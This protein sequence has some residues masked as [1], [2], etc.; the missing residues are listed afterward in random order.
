MRNEYQVVIIGGGVVGTFIAR[1]LSRYRLRVLLL[2]AENDLAMGATK[3]NSGII[4]G[5]FAESPESLRGKL[6]Y[7]GRCAFPRLEEELHFGYRQTGSLVL[8]TDPLE[9]PG[10]EALLERGR[11]N[12]LTDLSI[13]S[14]DE[15]LAMEPRV[16]PSVLGALF[17]RGAGVASPYEL[18]IALGENAVSNGVEIRLSSPVEQ[19]EARDEG[20]ILTLSRG[21][22]APEGGAS[23]DGWTGSLKAAGGDRGSSVTADFVINA[24]GVY[25]DRVA[26]MIGDNE[27]SIHPSKGEY[28]LFARG[29]GSIVRNVL[30]QMPTRKGKGVLVTST[31]HGNLMIGPDAQDGT[32]PADTGTDLESIRTILA[33]A[34]LT[35]KD[36]D[37]KQF[38][39]TFSGVRAISSTGDFIIGPSGINSRFIHVAGIQSPG[40]TASPAIARMVM[41]ILE[42]R[43]LPVG[44][45]AKPESLNPEFNPYRQAIIRPKTMTMKEAVKRTELPFGNLDRI[46]CRCEQVTEQE[47]LDSLSRGI[48]VTSTDAVKRRTR[49][50]M[51]WCQGSYCRPRVAE[52]LKVYLGLDVPPA[53]DIDHSGVNRVE[54]QDLVP[55]A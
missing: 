20:F 47:I 27:F 42:D 52:Y 45:S 28:V 3:A 7:P 36:F 14:R 44:D 35:V 51:G 25:A 21:P 54:K 40:L 19:I 46:V 50:G 53:E 33:R 48:P 4:H 5:G 26:R 38:I 49:A 22:G 2:E 9:L 34:R 1:E 43:G 39:R 24:A 16:N 15:V 32:S 18:A 8:C 11:R 41:G 17:C 37:L 30:F 12:G 55:K 23:G 6:C 29:T 13:L 31:F 10:L